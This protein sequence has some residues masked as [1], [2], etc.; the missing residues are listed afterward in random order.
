[1]YLVQYSSPHCSLTTEDQSHRHHSSLITHW[2]DLDV[3]YY[4]LA[5]CLA[6]CLLCHYYY[7]QSYYC[8]FIMIGLT[9]IL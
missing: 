4:Y 2:L 8:H 5:Q 6:N 1:M 3:I 9:V 7:C